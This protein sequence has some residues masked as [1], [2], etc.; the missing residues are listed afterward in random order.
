MF[1]E[2]LRLDP[3]NRNAITMMGMEFEEEGNDEEALRYYNEILKLY[4]TDYYAMFRRATCLRRIGALG[5]AENAYVQLTHG[6]PD[7]APAF[8]GLGLTQS[9]M[10]KLEDAEQSLSEALRLRPDL[11]QA[12]AELKALRERMQQRRQGV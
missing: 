2:I 3:D 11:H 12:D 8:L 10:G 5:K 6:R 4:P 1:A 9:R 7:L